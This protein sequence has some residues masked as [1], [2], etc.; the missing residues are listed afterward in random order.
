MVAE[1]EGTSQLND[2]QLETAW[3]EIGQ[4]L[5]D[6]RTHLDE[7]FAAVAAR[8]EI[9]PTDL[10]ALE[11]GESRPT[12]KEIQS[13][14]TALK[15]SHI[16]F[17]ADLSLIARLLIMDLCE[18]SMMSGD[19][20][21]TGENNTESVSLTGDACL[22]QNVPRTERQP[23]RAS[24]GWGV[25][26]EPGQITYYQMHAC[27][28]GLFKRTDREKAEIIYSW[29][30]L[31]D[32]DVKVF[33][34]VD[35]RTGLARPIG[36][37]AIRIVVYDKRAKRKIVIWSVE[38]KRTGNWQIRIREKSGA[39]ILRASYRPHCPVCHQDT[40]IIYGRPEAQ[41]WGCSN[42]PKCGGSSALEWEE[43]PSVRSEFTTP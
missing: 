4:R 33:T 12:G 1:I 31:A 17:A 38:L 13:L 43:R 34:S 16:D 27:L 21:P 24:N 15:I 2:E 14:L 29:T 11:R 6:T 35:A 23:R 30:S 42:Y 7:P 3:R 9:K 25:A 19:S 26:C 32:I 10:A 20:A 40:M 5:Q 22:A 18:P 39:A 41:F 28:R 36:E 37:D 8:A